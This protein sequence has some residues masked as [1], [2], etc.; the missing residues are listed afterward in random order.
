MRRGL[1][2]LLWLALALVPAGLARADYGQSRDWFDSLAADERAEIQSNLILLGHYTFL[3]DGQFGTGTFDAVVAFEKTRSTSPDGVLSS[4]DLQ[5][6]SDRAAQVYRDLGLNLVT[7]ERGQAKLVVPEA[8]LPVTASTDRGSSWSE[9]EGNVTLQTARVPAAEQSFKALFVALSTPA[10]KRK[11]TYSSFNN[12]R[13]VVTGEDDGRSFYLMYRNVG[14]ESVG[15]EVTWTR[16]F[17][18]EGSVVATYIASNFTPLQEIPPVEEVKKKSAGAIASIN[19]FGAFSLPADE[20]VISLN[21]EIADTTA[22]DF[23]R[24][25]KARPNARVL[26]LNSPGGYVDTALIIAREVSRREM[27]TMVAAGDGCYSACSY[28]FFAGAPR[29][30]DGELGVH[31]ISAEV[32]DLVL[33]QTTL[34]DVIAA[35]NEYGV[36]QTVIIRMLRTPPE[37]MYVFTKTELSAWDINRG[38][39]IKVADAGEAPPSVPEPVSDEPGGIVAFVHLAQESDRG[40]AERSLDYARNRWASVLGDAQPEIGETEAAGGTIYR[41]SVPTR[42]IESANAM[43][44]AIKS[45]GGGCFVTGL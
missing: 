26:L 24:A 10:G 8:L 12:S 11:V 4:G 6:L 35:L 40:E 2:L 28:I 34:S 25:L 36:Q 3:V 13:F 19:T 7:D 27:A 1:R 37:E 41:V 9:A 44:E 20:N 31:Q 43:C 5:A 32:A 45:A 21:G 38:G 14:T 33:A 18:D 29:Q 17:D 22:Q 30:A 15:Y 23:L 16:A 42:S 39:P